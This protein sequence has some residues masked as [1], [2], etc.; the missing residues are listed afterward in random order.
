MFELTGELD[1]QKTIWKENVMDFSCDEVT[2]RDLSLKQQEMSSIF[3]SL[4]TCT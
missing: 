3:L 4:L 1:V 2:F